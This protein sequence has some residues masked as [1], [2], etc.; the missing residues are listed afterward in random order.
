[1]DPP[2]LG[3][4]KMHLCY[5]CGFGLRMMKAC[6][7]LAA[8]QQKRCPRHPEA[9]LIYWPW[10]RGYLENYLHRVNG[11]GHDLDHWCRT[12]DIKNYRLQPSITPERAHEEAARVLAYLRRWGL[13][14]PEGQ[15]PVPVKGLYG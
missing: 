3:I 5:T 1:M 8:M 13:M 10:S 14:G 12:F 2:E 7:T 6:H 9:P 4:A 11:D 15:I